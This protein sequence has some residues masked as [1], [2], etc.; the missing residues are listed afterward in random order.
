MDDKKQ[1]MD[2]KEKRSL[3]RFR[4]WPVYKAAKSFRN[5]MRQ[6]ARN[7]PDSERFLLR[8]QL[9]RASDSI[10]LNI[11]EGSNKL[12]DVEFS[13][14]LNISE[15]SLEEAVCCLDLIL[16]DGHI[17]ESEFEC[18]LREAEELG[19]QLIAFGKKVRHEGIRL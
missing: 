12:S 17:T 9:S 3:F 5:K 19:A 15:T 2:K 11:A 14:Y 4:K 1:T 8:D 18:Y 10:C 6:V 16:D 7:L 13:K